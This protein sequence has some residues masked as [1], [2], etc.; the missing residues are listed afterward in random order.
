MELGKSLIYFILFHNITI[1][2]MFGTR[3]L[4]FIHPRVP[5]Y[6]FVLRQISCANYAISDK[7]RHNS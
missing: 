5:F 6:A 3:G 4:A 1:S 7:S 2:P